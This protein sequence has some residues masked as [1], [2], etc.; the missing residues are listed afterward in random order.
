[1]LMRSRSRDQCVQMLMRLLSVAVGMLSP[2]NLRVSDEWYTRF[3]VSWEPVS[4]PVQGYRLIYSPKGEGLADAGA[5]SPTKRSSFCV[6]VSRQGPTHQPLCW[7]R[8]LI[9][10]HQP[11]A[12]NHLRRQSPGS[13]HHRHQRAAHRGGHHAYAPLGRF[14]ALVRIKGSLNLWCVWSLQFTW[15][16]PISRPTASATT[17]SASS[18]VLTGRPRR[19]A[20]NC[21]RRTVSPLSF[22]FLVST[23]FKVVTSWNDDV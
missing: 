3:R 19:T 21:T 18:G 7:W 14:V 2:R 8:Q 9:H 15:T 20:S 5:V 1:M 10:A 12:W 23:S 22:H 6:S 13:V 16:W 11:A 4:S 17:S